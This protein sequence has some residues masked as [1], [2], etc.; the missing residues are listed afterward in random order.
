M[1][2]SSH[3]F[4]VQTAK[5][6]A[7]AS[8]SLVDRCYSIRDRLLGSPVFQRFSAS[9]PLTK[10]VA[11]TQA[12]A[13]FD[14]CAGFVYSQI[15]VACVRLDL[16][17]KLSSG[18]RT[19]AELSLELGLPAAATERLL[20]AAVSLRLLAPRGPNRFGL[21][22]LGAAL[23]GN[24]GIAAMILHHAMLYRDLEDPVALLRG[25]REATELAQYWAYAGT[26]QPAALDA[27]EVGEYSALMAASQ[28]FIARDVLDAYPFARHCCVLDIG[29]GEG[30]FVT[31]AAE[32]FPKLRFKLFDLPA[33]ADRA[34]KR[35]A[36]SPMASRT[37]V[38]S[39]SFTSDPLPHDVDLV[40]LIR[41]VHDHDDATVIALFKAIYEVLPSGGAVLVAEPMAGVP[42]AE[43]IGDAYF[44]LYLLA[45][46]QGRPRRP[47]EIAEMLRNAGF[48]SVTFHRTRRPMLVGVV[49][50]IRPNM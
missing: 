44:G 50:A 21:G 9:F 22:M 43:P 19:I 12:R 4:A 18:P 14:L 2:A 8:V 48:A 36:S 23:N 38:Y 20:L 7:G 28:T 35:L 33:V 39:G 41:L 16:F 30:A 27:E 34:R 46:G 1:P 40:S 6:V 45:M 32:R 13:L 25:E 11:N 5:S 24:P 47:D 26:T 37:A 29:G 49:S 15:L 17:K 42:G 10:S 3:E 31:T